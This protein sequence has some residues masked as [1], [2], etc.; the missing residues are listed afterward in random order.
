M[1]NE[2]NNNLNDVN[3]SFEGVNQKQISQDFNSKKSNN[4]IL[5]IVIIIVIIG[6]I[7]CVYPFIPKNDNFED[8]EL[9]VDMV[10]FGNKVVSLKEGDELSVDAWNPPIEV[11]LNEEELKLKKVP[12]LY[13]GVTLGTH[14]KDVIKKFNIKS[15]YAILNMEVATKEQDGTTD[16]IE[17]SFENYNSIPKSF[18]DCAIIFGYNKVDGKWQ[19]VEEDKISDADIVYYIDINGSSDEM[20]E[21]NEVIMVMIKY[22]N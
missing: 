1:N 13:N 21:K 19:I 22:N 4:K 18:L 16:I 7:G 14:V 3:K 8:Y 11:I 2:F 17:K 5:A 9:S 10:N 20:Y 15:G 12:V 6:L